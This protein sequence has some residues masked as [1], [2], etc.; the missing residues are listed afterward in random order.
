MEYSIEGFFNYIQDRQAILEKRKLGHKP[1]WTDDPVLRIHKFCNVYRRDDRG[2]RFILDRWR[3]VRIGSAQQL[4]EAC[5]YRV[6]NNSE[7][8]SLI[9]FPQYNNDD[10]ILE[11]N[12]LALDYAKDR[13]LRNNAYWTKLPFALG[14][15]IRS[16]YHPWLL[17]L[18]H[19]VMAESIQVKQL[20]NSGDVWRSLLEIQGIGKFIAGQIL[21][22][23]AEAQY[24]NLDDINEWVFIGP[25]A[26]EPL[27][28]M[29]EGIKELRNMQSTYLK[30]WHYPALTLSDIQHNLCE[31]RKYVN[32]HNGKG[33]KRYYLY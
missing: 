9:G 6:I 8:Y 2:T 22:D 21:L 10:E 25:G 33:K 7:L 24:L 16:Q 5:I 17:G 19:I 13:A 14:Y 15:N 29:A 4:F 23:L 18:S 1:P 28:H 3:N 26:K 31:Y 27:L 30:E 12:A 32:L 20:R 11:H